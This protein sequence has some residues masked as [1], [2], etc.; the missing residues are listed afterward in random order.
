[1][2]GGPQESEIQTALPPLHFN[3]VITLPGTT[4]TN[5]K[6]PEGAER[7]TE[8]L[9]QPWR[10]EGVCWYQRD[11][12]FP[13]SWQGKR[14]TLTL[15]RTKYTQ[16]WLDGQPLGEN[17]L[18]C[19]PQEYE[20]TR[21]AKPGRHT[22]TIAVN[23]LR[24]PPFGADAHQTSNNT[25]GNWNGIVGK[26]FLTPTDSLSIDDAQV[27]PDA[28]HRKIAVRLSLQ[29]AGSHRQIATVV[30]RAKG[31]GVSGKAVKT[32]DIECAP[33]QTSAQA[34]LDLGS[35][36]ALWDEYQPNLH[37]LTVTLDGDNI[38]DAKQVQFGLRDFKTSD[39]QF[40]INGK[41]IFLRGR[42]DGCV[43]PLTGHPPMDVQ[44]WLAYFRTCR[45]YGLNHVRF[46]TWTPPE[47]AFEAADQMGFYL[48]PELP[49]WGTFDEHASAALK[50]E[51]EAILRRFGN[52]PSFVMFSM[53]NEHWSVESVLAKLVGDLKALD[54]R[55]LYVRGTNAFS[56]LGR[57][58]EN[59][60]Y[61]ITA[62]VH[63][64]KGRNIRVRAAN[65]GT[66]NRGHVQTGPA[67]T[68]VTYD[69]A[70][71]TTELP[72]VTHEM[73]QYT[74]FPNYA[75]IKKYTGVS[76]PYNLQEFEKK[77]TDAGMRD[78]NVAF[79]KASGILATLCYRE[80]IEACL[81]T[82]KHGG[83]ELLDLLDFPGQGTALVGILDAFM[84]SKGLIRPAEW[85]QFCGPVVIL[86][87]FGQ[88]VWPQGDTFTADIDVSQYA[89][90]DM[91][92]STVSWTLKDSK[93]A[94]IEAGKLPA[95]DLARG[96]LRSVGRLS[97]PLNQAG[98][99]S[100]GLRIDGSKVL[101]SY[102]L[103]VYGPTPDAMPSNVKVVTGFDQSALQTLATGGRVL[104]VCDS[105]PLARSVG[106]GFATDFW[107]FPMF[108]NKPGTMGILCDPK[109]PA[110][111]GFATEFHSDW[112]WTNILLA[113]QPLV[114]DSLL[115]KGERAMVQAID[116]Y[117]RCHNLGLVFEV[118]VGKG[119]LLVCA[120]DL[121]G[122]S[123]T[124]PEARQLLNSL[125]SYAASDRFLPRVTVSPEA[126]TNLFRVVLPNDGWKATA[127]SFDDNW[128]GYSP[129]Q[130]V[131][132]NESRGWRAAS[133]SSA[134]QWCQ[135]DFP[136]PLDLNGGEITWGAPGAKYLVQ[137]TTD[138]VT[139]ETLTDQRENSLTGARHELRFTAKAAK[140]VKI[141]ISAWPGPGAV[142]VAEVRFYAPGN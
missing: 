57:P 105:R 63:D 15:E 139:W 134:P 14:V 5:R 30:L 88:Y 95:V 80:E 23:N 86:A 79:G 124:H 34:E 61:L 129:Q 70:T 4:D 82:P 38:Q 116:N 122:L 138:G 104:L 66:E 37:L 101:T 141:L 48:Q 50:P 24:L 26:I 77:L 98:Q 74:T 135:I 97:I 18:I 17:R 27:Y 39:H 73:G 115:P 31:P 47:A 120:A 29:N 19:T 108:H 46:H 87:K 136:M 107:N 84:D 137:Y 40:T 67:N 83:F 20:M 92:G 89:A 6:G 8:S 130:M 44:G 9:T 7:A 140:A 11:V 68:L 125:V 1:M 10:Y 94:V 90:H 117:E 64:A 106:A 41:T 100:L 114:L 127:S 121:L 96:G 3:D 128:K 28:P 21:S 36:A 22:L 118:K 71:A 111:H 76:R 25:Q 126:L 113:S 2:R 49:F 75:E 142:S 110:L 131:D 99:M 103:W 55:R 45:E 91:M 93:G 119:R 16:V 109:H 12:V 81:R 132:G 102:P 69:E 133:G 35:K 13:D 43:F 65:N 32:I 42:H 112:Q 33:G 52:H 51:A 85:R 53:G 56:S 78:Q 60:D 62:D 58:G 123:P 59:D 72:V 54:S